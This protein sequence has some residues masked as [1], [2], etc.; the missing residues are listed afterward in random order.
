LPLLLVFGPSV[1]VHPGEGSEIRSLM[2][3]L[4]GNNPRFSWEP[5]TT[6]LNYRL[7]RHYRGFGV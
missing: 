5:S 2:L 6:M 1:G 4:E 7:K 3:V